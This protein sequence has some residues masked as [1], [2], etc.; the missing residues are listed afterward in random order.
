VILLDTSALLWSL[1][2][3][4]R[5]EKALDADPQLVSTC[6]DMKTSRPYEMTTRAAAAEETRHRILSSTVA[7]SAQKLTLEIVLADVA[8]RSGVTTKTILRHFGSREGLFDAATE[9]NRGEIERERV[10]PVGD[11]PEAITA[12]VD[13]YEE[14]GD[15]VMR[16]LGQEHSDDRA[17]RVVD[18][19]RLVHREWVVTTFRPQL[20]RVPVGD[21]EAAVDLLVVATD[22]YT[23]KLL[24]RDRGLDRAATEQR[25][26]VLVHAVVNECA[27]TAAS[28]PR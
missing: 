8:E 9:F 14:R 7:L 28:A 5:L 1:G 12:V 15:W 24:R 21:R 11:V 20:D 10:A 6:R 25:M 16:M 22:V 18:I 17:R 27:A 4:K 3:P 13:H 19:G 26:R 2:T 23:W